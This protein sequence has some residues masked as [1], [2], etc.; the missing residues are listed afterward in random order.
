MDRRVGNLDRALSDM[1]AC[2]GVMLHE[3]DY[4]NRQTLK[5]HAEDMI[6]AGQKMLKQLEADERTS[7][8]E[9]F[10]K[11]YGHADPNAKNGS[12][13]D[14]AINAFLDGLLGPKGP[15]PGTTVLKLDIGPVLTKFRKYLRD[16]NTGPDH[17]VK[18]DALANML[19]SLI[20]E[21]GCEQAIA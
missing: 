9:S 19:D 1:L 18:V 8:T 21:Q 13:R 7:K 14:A 16:A 15:I 3:M 2:T 5:H 11:A 20:S 10:A 4:Q 12:N 17:T 6:G